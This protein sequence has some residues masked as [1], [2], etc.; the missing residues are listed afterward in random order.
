[1]SKQYTE[2]P[3]L[4]FN[5]KLPQLSKSEKD[6]L[7]LLVEAAKLIVPIYKLQENSEFPGANFYPHDVTK[8]EIED[9]AIENKD[10][11]SPF[12]VV[13]RTNGKLTAI[14]YH[15]KYGELLKSVADKLNKASALTE[16]KEFGRFLKLQ[17]EALREG[18]Y[19]EAII[20]GL[21]MKPYILDIAI[22]PTDRF[23]DRL[24]F[25]KAS[26]QCW[27]G[28]IDTERTK[29]FLDYKN[30]ILSA[31]RKALIPAE[32]INN[33][34]NVKVRVED[35]ILF[36]GLLARTKFVGVSLAYDLYIVEK[37]GSEVTLFN[38]LNDLR[39]KEQITPIF[40]KIF[41]KTF[42]EEFNSEDLKRGYLRAVLLHELA[43]SYLHYR[44]AAKN[45][46]D[47]FPCIDEL[48]A[49]I[50]GLRMA[51]SL[52]LKDRIT[53]KQLESMIVSFLCRGY[54]HIK[55]TKTSKSLLNYVVGGTI[56]I[57]F[58]IEHGALKQSAGKAVPN[59]MKIFVAL[60]ELFSILEQMLAR[61]TREEAESFI[62]KYD[63][64]TTF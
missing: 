56:F 20:A 15:V 4:E 29:K 50:L 28:V 19:E 36:T 33:H 38:Q 1:M 13:E 52:L 10:I 61:G 14:P 41:S 44:N 9:A 43:H 54:Y 53:Q 62:K 26:Y 37:Y 58:M 57:N 3:L 23:D 42:R 63:Q 8:E 22:G 27:V 39:L 12:T 34:D 40:N 60:H 30:I 47:L 18:T 25:A 49:T 17:A 64:C 48:A 7:K 2:Q 55:T 21:K 5:P 35:A 11:L 6:V 59:F 31:T 45:L 24:F 32:R 46:Q 51:G 16:N